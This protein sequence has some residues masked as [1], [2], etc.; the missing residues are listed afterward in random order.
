M[1]I[2]PLH[3]T[4]FPWRSLL[5]GAIT[6]FKETH[7]S[8]CHFP[9]LAGSN[10]MFHSYSCFILI[11]QISCCSLVVSYHPH[12]FSSACW[13]A[14]PVKRCPYGDYIV[15]KQ[16][17]QVKLSFAF[18]KVESFRTIVKQLQLY[19]CE[20]FYEI[21]CD[22]VKVSSSQLK[23]KWSLKYFEIIEPNSCQ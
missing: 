3:V 20:Q 15:Y 23:L 4:S 11:F 21:A 2:R 7:Y 14:L 9:T 12:V 5:Q 22:Y 10:S 13:K 8:C 17:H 6:V 19:L 1:A 18:R 16:A